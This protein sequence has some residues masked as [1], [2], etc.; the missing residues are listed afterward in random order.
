M[1][2]VA[3]VTAV[4]ET[5]LG[6]VGMAMAD[7]AEVEAA[8]MGTEVGPR[9][10]ALDTVA[11]E[12]EM[13]VEVAAGLAEVEGEVAELATAVAETVMAVAETV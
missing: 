2:V 5:E 3:M 1:A 10:A 8:E 13:V 9:A 6:V 12:V 4:A 11:E 7:V